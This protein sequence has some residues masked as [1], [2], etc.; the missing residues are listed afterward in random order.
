MRRPIS[1]SVISRF[2]IAVSSSTTASLGWEPPGTLKQLAEGQGKQ[3]VTHLYGQEINPETYAICKADMLLKGEGESADH[4]VGG[5]EHSTLSHDAF[6]AKDAFYFLPHQFH[7]GIQ[8]LPSVV[9]FIQGIDERQVI[10]SLLDLN[11]RFM[12]FG[13]IHCKDQLA[14]STFKFHR[15]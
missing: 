4:I 11:F 1:V 12:A 7:N 8:P 9:H 13:D 3:V 10:V 5:A 6:P 14:L 15:V 2:A